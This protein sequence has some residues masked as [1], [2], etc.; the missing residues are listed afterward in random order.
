MVGIKDQDTGQVHAE[1]PHSTDY[2]SLQGFVH[3]LT[4]VGATVYTEDH[5]AYSNMQGV[6]HETVKHSVGE[7]VNERATTNGVESFWA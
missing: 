1:V 5:K 4:V 7:Y 6:K 3:E 2:K